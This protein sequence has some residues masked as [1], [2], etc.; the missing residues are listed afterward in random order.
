MAFLGSAYTKSFPQYSQTSLPRHTRDDW[1]VLTKNV[2]IGHYAICFSKIKKRWGSKRLFATVCEGKYTER[3]W[4]WTHK[5]WNLHPPYSQI[6]SWLNRK[7]GPRQAITNVVGTCMGKRN[8]DPCLIEGSLEALIG[9]VHLQI[10]FSSKN[11]FSL[12]QRLCAVTKNYILVLSG[13]HSNSSIHCQLA[14]LLCISETII[15]SFI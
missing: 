2:I 11:F 1:V 4:M 7:I 14:I 13:P 15:P 12:K 9:G 3:M 10:E 6:A 5:K 8:Y